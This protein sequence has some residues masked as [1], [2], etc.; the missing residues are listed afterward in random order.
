MY[1]SKFSELEGCSNC[2]C[3]LLDRESMSL[4]SPQSIAHVFEVLT[5]QYITFPGCR[6]LFSESTIDCSGN[7][8]IVY[9]V[10]NNQNSLNQNKI[11]CC[12][13]LKEWLATNI[14]DLY[15]TIYIIYLV[16]CLF[17]LN[18]NTPKYK[19]VPI[20]NSMETVV[21]CFNEYIYRA[22]M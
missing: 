10:T 7:I 13:M 12:N 4:L 11:A 5:E 21:K 22:T 15:D 2:K 6:V 16:V 19:V 14:Q 17:L 18:S 1:C 8:V 9:T 3:T 20:L